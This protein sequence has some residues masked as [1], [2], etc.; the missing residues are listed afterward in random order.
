MTTITEMMKGAR[1]LCGPCTNVR[2]GESVLVVTDV[3]MVPIAE[4]VAAA[5]KE[6]GAEAV[7]AIIDQRASDSTEPPKPVAEAMKSSS[8]VFTPVSIS[9]THTRA[10]KDAVAAGARA[11]A[12]TAVTPEMMVSGGLDADFEQVKVT[13]RAVGA[14][15]AKAKTARVTNSFGTDLT[16]RVEGRRVNVMPCVV[17]PGE[18]SP[19]PTA[20]V[21]FSPIEG[22][23]NGIIVADASIPYLGIGLLKSPIRFTVRDGFIVSVEGGDREQVATLKTAWEKMADPNVYNV[24]EMGIGM[25]PMCRFTGIMLS[26]EGVQGSIH[27]GTGTNITLGGTVKAK[28]HYDL[29][30]AKPTL[31]LDD[32][33]LIQNGALML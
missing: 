14:R 17:E 19:A 27:I 21:N 3:G 24:A 26:D 20:E 33:L 12:L 13:C 7:I 2:A 22:S 10:V 32:Q 1:T 6:R 23:A 18:F 5:A 8:V 29:I 4:A 25:N 15:M 28:C 31:E 30:M 16:F 9:I 11:I